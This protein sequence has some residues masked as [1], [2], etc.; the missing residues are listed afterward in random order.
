MQPHNNQSAEET[1]KMSPEE[2]KAAMDSTE[3]P[4]EPADE[5]VGALTDNQGA[6]PPT[7]N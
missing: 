5:G 1:I 3:A 6:T 4:P 2:E 7:D